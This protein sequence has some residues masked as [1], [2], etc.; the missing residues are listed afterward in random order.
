LDFNDDVVLSQDTVL[1]GT[2][3]IDFVKT[4]NS[5]ATARNL[6][7]NSPVTA[8]HGIVGGNSPLDVLTTDMAGTTTIDTTA[9]SAAVLD[10]ND[11]V[12]LSQDTV[13][14]GTTSID[15]AK[16]IN[17]DGTPRDLT[18]NSPVTAFHGIVGGA[19]SLDVLSTD[20]SG[21]TT[22]DTT[23]IIADDLDFNDD[24]ILSQST[25]LTGIATMDFAK[26]VA[27]NG[28]DLTL[29]SSPIG[30]IV[31]QAAIFGGGNLRV[32]DASTQDYSA[33]SV[34][35]L[36]IDDASVAVTFHGTVATTGEVS[37]FSGGT[38]QLL[39]PINSQGVVHLTAAGLIDVQANITTINGMI[40][41]DSQ[42]GSIFM[43]DTS[44]I[45][46]QLGTIH[47][48]A[49]SSI[50]L[51]G[52]STQNNTSS[53]V[54][55]QSISGAIIDG[56]DSATNIVADVIG[57]RVELLAE[58]GIGSGNALE[59]QLAR[60]VAKNTLANDISIVET[61]LLTIERLEQT[62]NHVSVATLDGTIEVSNLGTVPD[63]IIVSPTGNL[64]LDANGLSAAIHVQDGIRTQGG[65]L[66]LNADVDIILEAAG[67]LTT[68]EGK[69]ELVAH[70]GSIHMQNGALSES[71]LGTI[72]LQAHSQIILSGLATGN[73]TVN[74]IMVTSQSAGIV[75][76]GDQQEELVADSPGARVTLTAVTGIGASNP[77]ETRLHQIVATNVGLGD[78]QLREAS[79]L[80]LVNVR[81]ENGFITVLSQGTILA[82]QV[83]TSNS[84]GIDDA[85][86]LT[87]VDILLETS[88]VGSD[89]LVGSI[90]A[91][92]SADVVLVAADDILETN[93]DDTNRV[94]ADDLMFLARN[95]VGDGDFAVGLTTEINDARGQIE[96][97]A[98]GDLVLVEIDSLNLASADGASD[99]NQIRTQNGEIRIR[100]GDSLQIIDPNPA[101]EGPART[102]DPEIVAEGAN[103]RIHFTVANEVTLGEGVQ[104]HAAQTSDRALVIEAGT[105][106]RVGAEVELMTGSSVGVARVFSPRPDAGVIDSAFYDHGSVAGDRLQSALGG[107]GAN[108]AVKVGTPGEEGLV[109]DID[110]GTETNRFQQLNG[111]AG[112][113]PLLIINH[114]YTEAEILGSMLNG[115]P[116]STAPIEVRFSVSHH[117]SFLIVSPE[118][119]QARIGGPAAVETV[120]GNLVSSTDNPA[121][122]F[123]PLVPQLEN[124]RAQIIVP[125]LSI[126]TR[127]FFAPAPLP[128]AE[129]RVLVDI[130]SQFTYLTSQFSTIEAASASGTVTRDEY[131][132]IRAISPDPGVES[133]A[134]P[135][136]LADDILSGDNLSRLFADLP[137]G[138][139][140]IEY[141]L[142]EGNE[143]TILRVEIRDGTPILTDLQGEPSRLKLEEVELEDGTESND[144]NLPDK[145]T[146][147]TDSTGSTDS[148][149]STESTKTLQATSVGAFAF[150]ARLR[151]RNLVPTSGRVRR[152]SNRI[153][154]LITPSS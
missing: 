37:V 77:L 114:V 27:T 100:A 152:F 98:R 10:F 19:S 61:N 112:N 113:D 74:A 53:A 109:L 64:L 121:T 41:L 9:I 8:F 120:A 55:I 3:S 96:G 15:F 22:I 149:G 89:I 108:L 52:I 144:E 40:S 90:I 142:G 68:S 91:K 47:M 59:T 7:L 56:G 94:I 78:L 11:D 50:T 75:D 106:F 147:L 79:G 14:T 6:T 67:D 104:M 44:R 139:Y 153:R 34:D 5:D 101:N 65:D 1:T 42:S 116:N 132:Q 21:T 29:S 28:H 12:V 118:V 148:V 138:T 72:S 20:M 151:R 127:L 63:A 115:R 92:N 131:F 130:P 48:R 13:L 25:V 38:V 70:A 141:V 87:T 88:G 35:S 140:E 76:G 23:A 103:G 102:L 119:E 43:S 69:I 85:G 145:A 18:L 99:L 33:I 107:F 31:A 82:T 146:E 95:N 39:A 129:R 60:L 32:L 66:I 93:F 126:P 80:E 124:G 117:P 111:L 86:Q 136:R 110:W 135:E 51:G 128:E 125:N 16:T 26:T 143:K 73:N 71:Q 36:K 81:T 84:N 83:E 46:S 4:V 134:P 150:S 97:A 30:V 2:T 123:G 137:D 105:K 54:F 133:V 57:S 154:E 45:T 62:G 122:F 24:V 49:D 58:Q 17:S